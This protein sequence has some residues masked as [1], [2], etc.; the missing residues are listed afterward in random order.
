[1]DSLAGR[2]VPPALGPLAAA[3]GWLLAAAFGCA[4]A[5]STPAPDPL[6]YRL[7]DSGSHWD[8]SGS[9]PVLE[10]LQPRYPEFFALVLDPARSEEPNLLEL[11]D[12]L[13]REPA[14]R[15]NYDALNALAIGYFEI[16]YRAGVRR[17]EMGFIS[18]GFRAAQIAAVPWRAYG[19]LEEG[20][21]RDAILDFFADAARG[22]KL[23]S[24]ATRGRLTAV[25]E[26][27][28][29]KEQDPARLERIEAIAAE[30]RA[31][32]EIR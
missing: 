18:G 4:G 27:L 5:A 13:E 22:E 31:A 2:R 8:V 24:A 7:A 28:A 25:V 9:D 21:L 30:L 29:R 3:A 12:D 14:S 17:G 23:G 6:R 19:E 10:D 11:R 26:S 32:S 20:A 1:M 16:N 15:R